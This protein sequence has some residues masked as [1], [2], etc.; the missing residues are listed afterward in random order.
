[1]LPDFKLCKKAVVIIIVSYWHKNRNKDQC[2]RLESPE[3]SPPIYGQLIY[4]KRAKNIQRGK[5]SF[6]SKWF[7][8]NRIFTFTVS[9]YTQ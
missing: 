1:M 9:H 6:F 4:N 5:D 2:N 8:Q 7:W 3:I